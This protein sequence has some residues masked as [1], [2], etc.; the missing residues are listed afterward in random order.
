MRTL[1]DGTFPTGKHLVPELLD[2][3]PVNTIWAFFRKA[4]R[5]MD[6]YRYVSCFWMQVVSISS[7]TQQRPQ[8]EAGWVCCQEI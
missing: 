5:Y 2:A 6:V 1:A 7:V 3:C 4:W 8:R